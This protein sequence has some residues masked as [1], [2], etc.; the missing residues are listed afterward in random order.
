MDIILLYVSMGLIIFGY[1]YYFLLLLIGRVKNISNSSG[2]DVTKD[3]ISEYDSINVIESKNYFTVYNIKRKVIKLAT[4]SYYGKDLSAISL[5]LIEAGISIVD[6]KKN[7]YIDIIRNIFSNLKLLYVL[8]I[9]ALFINN[10]SFNV[11]DARVSIFF[12]MIFVF[13]SYIVLDI[14]SQ[15][16]YWVSENIKKIKDIK[17]NNRDKI[18]NFM[19]KLILCDKFIY[20]GEIVMIIRFILI[21]FDIK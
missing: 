14:R 3:I 12:L 8:P 15:A 16:C 11:S 19:N 2:F 20:F 18:V 1:I 10:S 5:S 6:N 7:M 9:I 21:L 4:D 17:K 13:V